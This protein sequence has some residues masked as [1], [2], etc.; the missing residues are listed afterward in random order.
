MPSGNIDPKPPGYDRLERIPRCRRAV[1][2]YMAPN[3]VRIETDYT[4]WQGELFC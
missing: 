3:E 1:A 4:D 2:A